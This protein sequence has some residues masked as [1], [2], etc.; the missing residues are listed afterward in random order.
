LQE[1]RQL[2]GGELRQ[3]VMGDNDDELEWVLA[4]DDA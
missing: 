1:L 3:L 4:A 2:L